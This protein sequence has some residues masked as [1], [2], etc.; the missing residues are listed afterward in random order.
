MNGP[1]GRKDKGQG[2][3]PMPNVLYIAS[4]LGKP[5]SIPFYEKFMELSR[6]FSGDIVFSIGKG[7]EHARLK[8]IGEFRLHAH[9]YVRDNMLARNLN[10]FFMTVFHALK[11]HFFER[12]YQVIVS[13][14]PFIS[15]LAALF[16]SWVT[17]A[18]VIIEINGNFES[19]Y[20]YDSKDGFGN[21]AAMNMKD[22]ISRAFIA[23]VINRA[24]AVKLVY[25]KQLDPLG[26]TVNRGTKVFCFANFVPIRKFLEA[27]KTDGRYVL[28]LGYPWFLKGVDILI[29][30]F[31]MVCREFP[32]LKLK[33]V[34]W[35]PSGREYFENL[36]EGNPDIEL[37]DPVYYDEVIRLMAGCSL[38]V[39]A[40]RT[41]S[42]PRVLREAM[43]SEKPIIASDADGV[44]ELIRDGYNG[45]IFRKE[46]VEDLANKMRMILSDSGLARE[47]AKNGLAHVREHLSEER[48]AE[49]YRDMLE[50]VMRG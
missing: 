37:N 8:E 19:A 16:I 43:A 45:L 46:G 2:A 14:T 28:L 25:A 22:R 23:F 35:C 50:E 34:G 4:G 21:R 38:Y 26:I 31:R 3:T 41:D 18:K 24:D 11:I 6:H 33:V 15:G 29:K 42:S 36:A 49:N 13:T 44:P 40:S 20:K 30:A 39:L 10:S 17:G 48:Y 5:A 1:L 47:L 12:R 32:G 9:K 7:V 27:E